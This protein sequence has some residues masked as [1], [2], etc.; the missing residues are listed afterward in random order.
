MDV[1][2]Y[3]R[4]KRQDAAIG[5][6]ETPGRRIL[7]MDDEPAVLAVVAEYL[8]YAGYR[9]DGVVNGTAAIEAYQQ[10]VAA[11]D[12]YSIVIL[13]L[14]INA[15]MGGREAMVQ[16]RAIDP[17]VKVIISSGQSGDPI[18]ASY[19]DHGFAARLLKPYRLEHLEDTL[20]RLLT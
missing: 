6:I 2:N 15:G 3:S 12:P 13:D 8:Q 7:V 10:A 20:A 1:A 17:A 4:G 14:F 16:L 9:V 19:A 5:A 11:G 18:V